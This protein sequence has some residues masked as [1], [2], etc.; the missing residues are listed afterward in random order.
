MAEYTLVTRGV[1]TLT[2]ADA[3]TSKDVTLASPVKTG[4]SFITAAVRSVRKPVKVQRGAVSATEADTSPKTAAITAVTALEQAEVKA[5][6]RETRTGG[7]AGATIKLSGVAEVSLQWLGGALGVGEDIVAEYE[8]TEHLLARRGATLRLLS[9]TQVRAEWDVALEAGE[10]IVIAYEVYDVEAVG[11][12][13]KEQLFRL[14]RLLAIEGENTLQDL[15]TY[16]TA[17]NPTSYRIRTFDTKED[18]EDCTL[19]IEAG[20]ALEAGELSRHTV[21]I[22]MNVDKNRPSSITSLRTD[23]LTP[24]PEVS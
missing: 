15:M 1:I 19:D 18:A 3:G 16:D 5:T 4:S 9:T 11:D 24:T 12:D 6:F 21:T 8:V 22:T 13:L 2:S 20:E 14:Q 17:G 7:S 23:L 10:S